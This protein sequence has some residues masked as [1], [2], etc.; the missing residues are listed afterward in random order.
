MNR[1]SQDNQL[2]LSCYALSA[3][4]KLC[5]RSRTLNHKF[6]TT[7]LFLYPLN[8]EEAM[9]SCIHLPAIMGTAASACRGALVTMLQRAPN[10]C[11]TGTSS[12]LHRV[13][14]RG[15][16]ISSSTAS[17]RMPRVIAHR[18]KTQAM[19]AIDVPS[20]LDGPLR[21]IDEARQI[22]SA[23]HGGQ[24]GALPYDDRSVL[25]EIGRNR[26]GIDDRRAD[27]VRLLRRH[28]YSLPSLVGQVSLCSCFTQHTK[29]AFAAPCMTKAWRYS[30]SIPLSLADNKGP[31]AEGRPGLGLCRP[32]VLRDQV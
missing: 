6:I 27:L 8:S 15:M 28:N 14:I 11:L 16:A 1:Q 2:C 21:A 32:W 13:I 23:V 3:K 22:A 26:G 4:F 30:Q 10:E 9:S 17:P 5:F 24:A 20:T 12:S 18:T 29:D 25:Q 7:R 31:G 19:A